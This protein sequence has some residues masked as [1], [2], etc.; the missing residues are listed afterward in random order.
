MKYEVQSFSGLQ[1]FPPTQAYE[2]L[3]GQ[4]LLFLRPWG[5]QDYNQKFA[6]EISHYLS[7]AQADID[8]TSPFDFLENL[9]SLANKVRISILLAHDFFLKSENNSVFSVG[10]EIA[11]LMQNKNEIAWGTVGRFNIQKYNSEGVVNI[12]SV[13]TERDQD[14]LLPIELVGVEKDLDIRLGSIRLK[15]ENLIVSSTFNMN[16]SFE[17]SSDQKDLNLK[18]HPESNSNYWFSKIK[19]E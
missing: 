19:F 14:V 11:V 17:L 12:S 8:V 7:T 15:N 10:F 16:L 5:S 3:D 9:T 1:K 13:G 6:D 4:L 2:L 18:A